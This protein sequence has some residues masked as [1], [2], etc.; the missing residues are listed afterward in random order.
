ME[1]A[2]QSIKDTYQRITDTIVEQLE[3]GKK[4]WIRLG[5]GYARRSAIIPRRTAGEAY[6][7]INVIML[8]V[9]GQTFGHEQRRVYP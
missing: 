2:M 9:T 3:T 7:G 4:P 8:W 5:R 6:R 1:T